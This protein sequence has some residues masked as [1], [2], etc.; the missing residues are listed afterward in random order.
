MKPFALAPERRQGIP[1][2]TW[3]SH[4]GSPS[5]HTDAP[6]A[7]QSSEGNALSDAPDHADTEEFMRNQKKITAAMWF[8][9]CGILVNSRCGLLLP[10]APH[11]V[12]RRTLEIRMDLS[13]FRGTYIS[14]TVTVELSQQYVVL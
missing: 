10:R 7:C 3:L 11:R 2:E 13:R 4:K 12:P 9:W 8:P 5:M 1:L 6:D 14:D